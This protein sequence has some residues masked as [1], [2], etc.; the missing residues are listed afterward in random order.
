MSFAGVPGG[1][2]LF[3]YDGSEK[4]K[5]AIRKVGRRLCDGRRAITL[6]VL[7][8]PHQ[9]A[10]KVADGRGADIVVVGSHGRTGIIRLLLES[11]SA[12][13]AGATD[14]PVLIVHGV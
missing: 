9:Q 10:R 12:A 5:A 1:P 4:A 3:A 2:H 14:G 6:T 13:T 11:I 8:A 7:D